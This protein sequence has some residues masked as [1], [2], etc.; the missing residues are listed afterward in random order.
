MEDSLKVMNSL[1]S[2]Y[3]DFNYQIDESNVLLI[4]T[5]KVG[6]IDSSF[7]SQIKLNPLKYSNSDRRIFS[8]ILF[9]KS[10]EINS[11]FRYLDLGVIVYDYKP[12]KEDLFEDIRYIIFN[13]G[14]IDTNSN[15]FKNSHKILD[16]KDKLLL[17][18]PI[19][20]RK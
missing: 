11:C 13:D 12:T 5:N 19:D 1:L 9:L 4:G 15:R 2:S 16:T 17:I 14:H 7:L 20:K 8:I 18:A 6:K 3:S 10:N